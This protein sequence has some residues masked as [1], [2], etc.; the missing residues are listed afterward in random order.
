MVNICNR[1]AKSRNLCFGTNPDPSKSK[2]KCI[3]FSTS[4][5]DHLNLMPIMLN[6]NPLPWVTKVNHL[7]NVLQSDNSMEIDIRSKRGRFIGTVNSLLQELHFANPKMLTNLINTYATSFYGS[8]L[9]DL[10]GKECDRLFKSWN[11]TIRQVFKLDRCTH[12]Y[13]IEPASKVLHPKVML[14]S[15]LVTFHKSLLN[16]SK[17]EVRF[18]TRLVD[19]DQ[20]TVLGRNLQRILEEC[21]L[22]EK[23]ISKLTCSLVK[24]KCRYHEIPAE[25]SWRLDIVDELLSVRMENLC[26]EGFKENELEEM[27]RL[28]CT[29]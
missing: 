21:D 25:E 22:K 4:K 5:K 14:A 18:L 29:T 2:T 11:V 13:L 8:S 1:F 23:D 27:L 9:W 7:G 20:R 26:I 16:S 17:F 12:K 24:K 15:R 6:G 10:Y 28:I 19:H 3:L